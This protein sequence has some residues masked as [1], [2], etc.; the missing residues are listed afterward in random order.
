MIGGSWTEKDKH[1]TDKENYARLISAPRQPDLNQR[2]ILN[3]LTQALLPELFLS[4]MT[5]VLMGT[6]CPPRS[7]L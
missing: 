3:L 4:R 7:T 2:N 1:I 5:N 6:M